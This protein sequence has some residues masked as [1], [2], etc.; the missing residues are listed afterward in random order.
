M[1]LLLSVPVSSKPED[2]LKNTAYSCNINFFTPEFPVP[3]FFTCSLIFLSC[4]IF[5]PFFHLTGSFSYNIRVK[6]CL[7]PDL[8]STNYSAALQIPQFS[9]KSSITYLILCNNQ[10]YSGKKR[11]RT[12]YPLYWHRI[13]RSDELKSI[14]IIYKDCYKRR[15]IPSFPENR[16]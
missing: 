6:R 4:I 10:F 11:K 12:I 5:L 15:I 13:S 9:Y 2:I 7:S 1:P 3:I 16:K 14:C 8:I